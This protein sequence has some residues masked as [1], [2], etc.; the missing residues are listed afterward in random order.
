MSAQQQLP[1]HLVSLIVGLANDAF[2]EKHAVVCQI[3]SDTGKQWVESNPLLIRR[4]TNTV[5]EVA[6][7]LRQHRR[8]FKL[9]LRE[10]SHLDPED[11]DEMIDEI[12]AIAAA[13]PTLD[14]VIQRA[15]YGFFALTEDADFSCEIFEKT[16]Y[17]LAFKLANQLSGLSLKMRRQYLT[18]VIGT[19]RRENPELDLAVHD[20]ITY[21]TEDPVLVQ[22]VKTNLP[23]WAITELELDEEDYEPIAANDSDDSLNVFK[24]ANRNKK[25]RERWLSVVN[26]Q[27]WASRNAPIRSLFFELWESNRECRF[28]K[29]MEMTLATGV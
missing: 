28:Q 13:D 24:W 3:D 16:F 20:F 18:Q 29:I 22:L 26:G 10:L 27:Q 7:V 6:N 2:N 21:Y 23:D 9:A 17:P 19:I 12:G 8:F 14:E 15:A 25:N 4:L 5:R 11:T 1:I